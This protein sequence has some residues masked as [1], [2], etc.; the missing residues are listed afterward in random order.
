[1]YYQ[2]N[3][4]IRV[5]CTKDN[6]ENLKQYGYLKHTNR[7][8]IVIETISL[9]TSNIPLEWLYDQSKKKKMHP[10]YKYTF[11]FTKKEKIRIVEH[12]YD[13]LY[14]AEFEHYTLKKLTFAST[15]TI[16]IHSN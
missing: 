16:L 5:Y 10:H 2:N 6:L 9:R 11:V 1:M 15:L 3:Q 7:Y 14:H 12:S 4:S 8:S 13:F